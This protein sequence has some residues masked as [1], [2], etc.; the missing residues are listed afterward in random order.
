LQSAKRAKKSAAPAADDDGGEGGGGSLLAEGP[1]GSVWPGSRVDIG[2]KIE[3]VTFCVVSRPNPTEK[4]WKPYCFCGEEAVM[5]DGLIVCP[6]RK[7]DFVLPG[8]QGLEF[9]IEQMLNKLLDRAESGA[10]SLGRY[11][12]PWLKP[13]C[14]CR[15]ALKLCMYFGDRSGLFWY[16]QCNNNKCNVEKVRPF[17]VRHK[18]GLYFQRYPETKEALVR[19]MQTGKPK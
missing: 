14:K 11:Y 17:E 8:V 5:C 13:I 10:D 15:Q 9:Y 4:T 19:I 16:M 3:K 12:I 7:C 2:W 1:S 6:A 18:L